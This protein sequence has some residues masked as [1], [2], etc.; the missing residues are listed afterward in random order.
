MYRT[1]DL[2]RYLSDGRIEFIGRIDQ[3]VKLRGFRIELDE[4]AAVLGGYPGMRECA[5]LVRED[6]PGDRR[7]VAYV[8]PNDERRT[9]NDELNHKG[10]KGFPECLLQCTTLTDATS[11]SSI[12]HRRSSDPR[13]VAPPHAWCYNNYRPS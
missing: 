11:P 5:V 12:V 1:G 9:T 8:V 13:P 4:I 2:C 3:Q 10:H 7:L 6:V